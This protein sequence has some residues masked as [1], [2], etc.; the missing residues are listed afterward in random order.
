LYSLYIKRYSVYWKEHECSRLLEVIID[1]KV[2]CW[3]KYKHVFI[4]LCINLFIYV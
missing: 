4:C 3:C 1:Q 2:G